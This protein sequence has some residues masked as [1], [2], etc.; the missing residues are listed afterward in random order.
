MIDFETERLFQGVGDRLKALFI[1]EAQTQGLLRRDEVAYF[2]V[3]ACEE[4]ALM[5]DSPQGLEAAALK[6][7]AFQ[8]MAKEW[9]ALV[10][11]PRFADLDNYYDAEMRGEVDG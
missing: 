11:S 8:E 10:T 4:L 6:C 3:A 9:D 7:E 2:V 5:S 1:H